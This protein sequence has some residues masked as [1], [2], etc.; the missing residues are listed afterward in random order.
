ML[1]L[2]L[3]PLFFTLA[4]WM[5]ELMSIVLTPFPFCGQSGSELVFLKTPKDRAVYSLMA[6]ATVG[7][8]VIT[9]VGLGNMAFV[10]KRKQ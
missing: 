6:A 3:H 7:V 1:T 8:V 2:S 4:E 5:H 9:M 10:G